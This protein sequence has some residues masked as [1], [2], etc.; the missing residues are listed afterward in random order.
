MTADQL[1]IFGMWQSV[2]GDELLTLRKRELRNLLTSYADEADVFS[3]IIQNALD[4]IFLAHEQGLYNDISTPRLDIVIGRRAE[5][6]DYLLVCD[7]GVGMSRAVASRFTMPGFTHTKSLGRTIGYKGVGASFFFAAANNIAFQTQD[8]EGDQTTA[9]VTGSFRWIMSTSEPPPTPTSSFVCPE[10]ARPL[11]PTSRGTAVYYEFHPD[12]KPRNLSYIVRLNNEDPLRELRHWA[13]YLCAKTALGYLHNVKD[14]PLTIGLHL[15]RGAACH[16]TQWSLGSFNLDDRQLGYP[17]PWAVLRVHHDLAD[18]ESLPKAQQG[19][20]HKAKHQALRLHWSRAELLNLSQ[21]NFTPEE[22]QLV[23]EHF[24]FLDIFFAYSTDLMDVI[25]RRTGS[26]ANVLRY[27]IRLACDGVPQGRI[28]DFDLTRNQGLARQAHA[29]VAFEGLELDTGRKI[30]ANELV[31]AVVRKITVRAMT[32]LATYRWALKKKSRPDPSSNLDGWRSD[33]KER[34]SQSIVR[35][36]FLSLG[37]R[38]PISVDPDTENDVIA[39][40]AALLAR[41]VLLGYEIVALSG[42]NRY[43]GLVNILTNPGKLTDEVDPFS[44]RYS[45][46]QRGGRHRVLEFKL[47]FDSV[48]VDFGDKTKQPQDIDLLVCWTLPE[49]NVN[50]GTIRYTYGDRNDFRETYGMTHLW[51]DAEETSSI[52]IICLKHFIT[53]KLKFVESAAG[54]PGVGTSRFIQLLEDE[55]LASL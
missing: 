52:P 10:N 26:R 11:L 13:S 37:E 17:Y 32:H 5:D 42:F 34:T 12:L 53:E 29:V 23:T 2:S 55:K 14:I 7:N 4:A 30:P 38:A 1:D 24:E 36:L 3:E 21:L 16:P 19:F 49:I 35:R 39:L 9:T 6:P 27:G 28:I 45:E 44:V 40:F 31:M 25:H 15:D 47:H 48:L 22:E 50:R 51:L 41:E 54:N 43:D 8:A 33:T 46:H 18:I 20:Q